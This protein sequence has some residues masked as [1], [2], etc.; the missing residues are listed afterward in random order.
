MASH[1]TPTGTEATD[2]E[3]RGLVAQLTLEE[4]LSLVVGE[5]FWSLPEIPRI[6]LRKLRVSDG[7]VGVRGVTWDERDTSLLFPS[8]TALAAAWDPEVTRRAGFI[9]GA[10]TRDKDIHVLLA[11][12]VNLHRSPLGGRHFECYSEDPLLTSRIATAFIEGVQSAGVGATIKHFVGNETEDD[13]MSYDSRIDER[14]L[15]EVYL[16]PFEEAVRTG[17][18]W[19]V[20]SAYNQVNGETMTENSRLVNGVLKDEW[21]FDGVVVSDWMAVRS[22]EAAAAGGTDVAM[23]GPTEVWGEPLLAAVRE[24]RVAEAVIDDR[25][26]RVLRL[27]AR[28]GVLGDR[29]PATTTTPD[30]AVATLRAIAARAMVLLGNDGTLPLDTSALSRVALIGP[31][32]LRLSAQGGGSAHVNP[33]HVVSIPEGLRAALGAGVELTL[34]EGAFTHRALADLSLDMATDPDDG[35]AGLR[36]EFLD[37]DGNVLGSEHRLGSSLMFWPDN[38]PAGAT[39]IRL[40][41]NITPTITGTNILDVRGAG[42]FEVT[43]D[44]A[45][46]TIDMT[47]PEGTDAIEAIMRPE[48][49]RIEIEATAGTPVAV[50][51]DFTQGSRFFMAALGLG[52]ANPRLSEDAELDAAVEAAR[53]ADVAVVVVGT[54]DDIESEGFDR[55]DL[56]LP[57]RSDELVRRVAAANPRTVVVVNAGSPVLMPWRDEVAAVVWAWLPGQEGGASLGDVLTGVVEPGGRLPTTYPAAAADVPVYSTERV[58]GGHDY[59][60]RS[61]NIGYRAWAL[62]EAAPAYPFGHGLGYTTWEY[63]GVAVKG[64]ASGLTVEIAVANTGDRAGREVAQVYLETA[65]GTLMG[66]QE[67]IRLVGFAAIDAPS[68]AKVTATVEI[69]ARTLARWDERGAAW[70]TTPGTYRLRVGRSLGDLRLDADVTL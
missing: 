46:R 38:I 68:G 67:P 31:N 36:A 35:E 23:P 3:L 10:Q 6:G 48:A 42:R 32:A 34:T 2:E 40:R 21:G 43:I 25:V 18:V 61:S 19:L 47:A 37:A 49:T 51:V 7:P 45:T 5:D 14:S 66:R 62:G 52:W 24:G 55:K 8:P 57:G 53:A 56:A 54:T 22:T 60:V 41:V 26:E 13:R 20:M 63:E 17:R 1:T 28:V 16:A 50:S 33:S 4:K 59:A 15:R 12:T 30:D 58:D 64:D 65:D 44:G 39:V 70:V 11:P 29:T 69:D 9:M 27:A